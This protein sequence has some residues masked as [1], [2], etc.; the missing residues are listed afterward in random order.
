[1]SYSEV[2]E[3]L[4]LNL[5]IKNCHKNTYYK[6]LIFM[7]GI[8]SEN[9][10]TEEI[11]C[12]HDG[13]EIIF[14]KKIA[15]NFF[16][17]KRQKVK[18]NIIKKQ[19]LNNSNF[20]KKVSER[21][22]LLSS[23]ISSPNSIYERKLNEKNQNSEIMCIKIEK[24]KSNLINKGYSI[25]DYLKSGVKF[26]CFISMDYSKSKNNSSLKD[27]QINYLNILNNVSNAIVNY[28][29]NH[30][31]YVLGYGAKTFNSSSSKAIFNLNMKENDSGI[32]TIEK[33]IQHFNSSLF[34]SKIIP[35]GNVILSSLIKEV[36]NQIYKLYEIR[37]YNISFIVT[38]GN[39]EQSDIQNT[40]DAIIESSYLPLTIFIIGVGKNDFTKMKMVGK[41]HKCSSLGME[42][43]RNNV[44]FASLIDDFSNDDEKLISWC[45]KELSKQIINFYDLIKSSPEN[46]HH[47]NLSN[48]EKSF[49]LYSRSVF[50]EKSLLSES[51]NI[52]DNLK[53]INNQIENIKIDALNNYNPY[54][55]NKNKI[56]IKN[57]DN[58][59]T[60]ELSEKK[61]VNKKPQIYES[62]LNKNENNM[63]DSNFN[64]DNHMNNNNNINNI[65]TKYEL[66]STITRTGDEPTNTP[67][68]DTR[69]YIPKP[70][71]SIYEDIKDNPYNKTPKDDEKETVQGPAPIIIENKKYYHQTQ[72]IYESNQD[73]NNYNP[74]FEDLKR[75]KSGNIEKSNN[76][77]GQ[78]GQK[79]MNNF[80]GASE[81]NSTN[82]SENIKNSNFYLFGNYSID[83]SNI[84]Y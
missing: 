83:S 53:E 65:N 82:N 27:N 71:D 48:I 76:S 21:I 43:M 13:L 49:N 81:F 5:S 2:D 1:M 3:K 50:I 57:D 64:I 70:K 33:V 55:E 79:K 67:T 72:S 37:Y 18:I 8:S 68:P 69:F 62:V 52:K 4:L 32:N 40:I 30:L 46:I 16:F 36:T 60:K 58:Y 10:E 45:I 28:T 44:L 84:K 61:F 11:K 63:L 42:K 54:L 25:F 14:S 24:D 75:A 35:E 74:Y 77:M 31:F 80:S 47:N 38:R 15:C 7:E 20:S 59:T 39:I 29:K 78:I 56:N 26:S 51:Q 12:N 9:L 34:D 41:D 23:L 17:G 66:K 6:M 73:L 22:T 19:L